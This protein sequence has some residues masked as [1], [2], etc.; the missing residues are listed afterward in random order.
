MSGKHITDCAASMLCPLSTFPIQ[1]L[2]FY[3][4]KVS[5]EIFIFVL[6]GKLNGALQYNMLVLH[7]HKYYVCLRVCPTIVIDVQG[8]SV[9]FMTITF[10]VH[11]SALGIFLFSKLLQILG[12]MKYPWGFVLYVVSGY[13]EIEGLTRGTL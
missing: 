2:V 4:S 12:P 6:T 13:L 9:F 7:K 5:W 11:C 10:K 1:D 3:A 8:C